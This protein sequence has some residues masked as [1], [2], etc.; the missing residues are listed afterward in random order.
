MTFA[1]NP[2]PINAKKQEVIKKVAQEN[3]ELAD[4]EL[5]IAKAIR[6]L[7]LM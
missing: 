6:T 7:N 1:S 4:G 3:F 5:S 2:A